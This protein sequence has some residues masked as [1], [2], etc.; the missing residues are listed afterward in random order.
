MHNGIKPASLV[1]PGV[2]AA[3]A[4]GKLLRDRPALWEQADL[5]ERGKLLLSM[6]DAVYVDSVEEKSIVAIR[7]KLDFRPP[8]EHIE[9]VLNHYGPP[10]PNGCIR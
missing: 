9:T 10:S 7:P 5:T 2:D 6:L 3:K 1:V 8:V 4:A